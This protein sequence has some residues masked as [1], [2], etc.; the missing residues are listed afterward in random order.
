MGKKPRCQLVRA[1]C[2]P[3]RLPFKQDFFL[4]LVILVCPCFFQ[5]GHNGGEQVAVFRLLHALGGKTHLGKGQ[6]VG[7]FDNGVA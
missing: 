2:K 4:V 1:L 7:M 6:A 3:E 5:Y